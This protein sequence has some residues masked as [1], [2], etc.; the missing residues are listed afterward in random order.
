M[1]PD[2]CS[3]SYCT[4]DDAYD[5]IKIRWVQVHCLSKIDLKDA[6]RLI[7]VHPS[8]WNLLGICW[9]TRF[10]VDTCLPF[11][12]KS[13]PYLFNRLSEAIHWILVNRRG[14]HYLL[15]YLDEFHT[16]GPPDSPICSNN[17][18]SMLSLY[19]RIN[20]P[21]KSSKI[22]CPSTAITFLE[23]HLDTI[24][25]EASITPECKDALLAE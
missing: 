24:A 7:P 11:G 8:Q 13:A 2:D 12:L 18:N 16:A 15:N 23:I 14:T 9:K 6:F 10:Y 21:V 4:I 17:L 5:F 20:A 19:Q 25:I 3:L 1:N 22:E